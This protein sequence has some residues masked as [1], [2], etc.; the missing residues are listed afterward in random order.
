MLCREEPLR[1]D[2]EGLAALYLEIGEARAP[3]VLA[4]ALRDLAEGV[5]RARELRRDGRLFDLALCADRLERIAGAIGLTGLARVAADVADLSES[6]D[7][8]ALAA[9]LARLDRVAHQSLRMIWR[10][11]EMS[12]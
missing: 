10:L 7:R 12:G 3:E 4:E 6:G 2:P 5:A 1:L 9:T 8:A 11:Q